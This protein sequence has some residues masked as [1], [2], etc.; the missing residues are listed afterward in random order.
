MA[1]LSLF[2][3]RIPSCQYFFSDGSRADFISGRYATADEYKIAEL[4]KEIKAGHPHIYID[5]KEAEVDAEQLDPLEVIK[6]KAIAEYI[7][8]QA[9]RAGT[10]FGNTDQSSSKAGIMTTT[11]TT[12]SEAGADSTSGAAKLNIKVGAK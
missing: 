12:A 8:Q 10:N 1:T 11:D 9:A 5:S 2:K 4:N 6:R 3:C 7:A